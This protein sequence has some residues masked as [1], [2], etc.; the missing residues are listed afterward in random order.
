MEVARSRTVMTEASSAERERP[1]GAG[2]PAS[3]TSVGRIAA[4]VD[5]LAHR[6][7]WLPGEDRFNR[8]VEDLA[9]PKR[10]VQAWVVFPALQVADS[11]VIDCDCLCELLP[12]QAAL[13]AEY[14]DPVV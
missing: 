1:S 7:H 3:R 9:D 13:R 14:S 12:A 4:P 8:Q 10:Q 11:L 5:F 6:L 2:R